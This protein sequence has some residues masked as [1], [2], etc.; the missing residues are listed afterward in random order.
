MLYFC[1]PNLNPFVR[2]K[3]K[4]LILFACLVLGCWNGLHAQTAKTSNEEQRL[5]FS[6]G[7]I[8]ETN[9]SGF[10]HTG[11]TGGN[12]RMKTGVTAGGFLNLG[13]TS[14]FSVQ[15]E[16]LFHYK[17]SDFEWEGER[18]QFQYFGAE[19]PIY[20]LYHWHLPGGKTFF[21]GVGPYTEF[22]LDATFKRNGVKGDLYEKD[23]ATGLP[24]LR[25]SNT[26]FAVK[27][28]YELRCGIQFNLS[29]K[30][31]V[32]NLLEANS[33][34]VQMRPHAIHAGIAYRFGK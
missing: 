23:E 31:S 28:G 34:T 33:H 20:A 9:C 30:T 22:G 26:G 13:I 32:T 12:C 1:I 7:P 3:R 19:L 5:S 15:C 25:D 14:A 11:V 8:L 6:G 27:L 4:H 2:M 10:L 18:G 16:L 17:H 29:Y 24:I 21:A